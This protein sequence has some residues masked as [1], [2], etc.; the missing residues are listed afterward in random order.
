MNTNDFTNVLLIVAPV[1]MAVGGMY[2]V[3]KNLFDRDY[4]LKLIENKRMMQK[5]LLP[6]KLQALERMVVFL[7]RIKPE[8][9]IIRVMQPGMNARDLHLDLLAAIRS[10]YEHNV[11]QQVYISASYWKYIKQAKDD[12][13]TKINRASE[14]VTPTDK[15]IE[16]SKKIME[17]MAIDEQSPIDVALM[18]L[19]AEAMQL[20]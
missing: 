3:I 6:L 4:R 5:E 16:L 7:E 19:N 2:L 13:L 15:A 17:L 18:I 12:V 8:N 14:A 1:F 10:E 20:G 9:V 11:S